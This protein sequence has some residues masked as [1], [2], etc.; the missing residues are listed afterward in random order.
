LPVVPVELAGS[1]WLVAPYGAVA[2]VHN[3]RSNPAVTLRRGRSTERLLARE[4]GPDEAG[5]VLKRYVHVATRARG[6]FTAG[7]DAHDAAFVAEA[8]RHPVFELRPIVPAAVDDRHV[9]AEV[10]PTTLR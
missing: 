10:G 1:R 5:P 8:A 2:W 9:G 7:S 4:A 3:A 6:S